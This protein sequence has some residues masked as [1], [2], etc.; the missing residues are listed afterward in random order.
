M[1]LRNYS[2]EELIAIV[3]SGDNRAFE[4]LV[5]RYEGL[6]AR[7]VIGML[8]SGSEAEDVGQEVFIRLF[9]SLKDFKAEAA[10]SSYLCRIAINLSLNAIKKRQR[11]LMIFSSQS[12][13]ETVVEQ[14]A[15]SFD[16]DD[17]KE[18][19]HKGLAQL[20]PEH[21]AVI[22]L[23]SLQGYSVKEVGAI[24]NLPQG[25]VMSRYKRAQEKLK[26]I[27]NKLK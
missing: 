12:K 16:S 25:T 21:R 14:G 27:L 2:D 9:R 6:V 5:K 13:A 10:L 1:E 23:R 7:T 4:M 15:N 8:G 24:L 18:W 19:L 22:V 17:Q 3:L 11:F 20:K 26:E